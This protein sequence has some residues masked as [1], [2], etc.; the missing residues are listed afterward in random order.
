[1]PRASFK[2]KPP[3][4]LRPWH[5]KNDIMPK[6]LK[7]SALQDNL[8]EQGAFVSVKNVNEDDMAPYY[9]IKEIADMALKNEICYEIGKH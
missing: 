1:M 5:Q 6:D 9:A 2:D 8:R 7:I 3:E 4:P